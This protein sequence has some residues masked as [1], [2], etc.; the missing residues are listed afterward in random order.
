MDANR[1]AMRLWGYVQT[2]WRVGQAAL[3]GLDWPAVFQTAAIHNITMNP[4][5]FQKIQQLELY[6]IRRVAKKDGS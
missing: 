4:S 5:M 1:S 6:E 3:I 2:M